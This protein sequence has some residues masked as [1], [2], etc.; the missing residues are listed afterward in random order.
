MFIRYKE[1]TGMKLKLNGT[2]FILPFH[3]VMNI[4]GEEVVESLT[5][6]EKREFVDNILSSESCIAGLSWEE[7]F[8]ET[9]NKRNTEVAIDIISNYICKINDYKIEDKEV[10]S[11]DKVR[12]MEKGNER[13]SNFSNLSLGD[14]VSIGIDTDTNKE[15]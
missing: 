15:K 11:R 3:K 12:K 2:Q 9:W 1:T 7:Y 6:E 8:R 10:M 14:K 4:N 13:V 5:N